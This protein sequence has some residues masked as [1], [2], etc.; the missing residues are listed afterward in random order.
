MPVSGHTQEVRWR[1]PC[2]LRV[3]RDRVYT[4]KTR[5]L[6]PPHP[7]LSIS[8]DHIKEVDNVRLLGVTLDSKLTFEKH[9]RSLS[10]SIA[11]KTGLLR[12]CFRTFACDSTVIKSFYAFILPHFE[13][14]APVWMSAANCHLKLLDRALNS[15]KYISPA[16]SLDLDHRRRV[17]ALSIFFKVLNNR[18]HPLRSVLPEFFNPVR[19][20]RFARNLNG[21]AINF[22]NVS[23]TQ[24]SR[25]FLPSMITTWNKLPNEIVYSSNITSFKSHVNTF[26]KQ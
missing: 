6:N 12:K 16:L 17:G 8:G 13:Y 18:Q 20:T 9:I 11:Q 14:C 19:M 22:M 21:L 4:I 7:C 23:T 5:T 25:C 24:F 1:S 3:A 10:S 15:I 26:L 2:T